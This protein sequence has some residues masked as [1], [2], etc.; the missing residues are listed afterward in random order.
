MGRC[1]QTHSLSA[2]H[3]PQE[4]W[5]QTRPKPTK[6]SGEHHLSD[7]WQRK[8]KTNNE[9]ESSPASDIFFNLTTD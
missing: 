3:T 5:W 7:P 1:R 6:Q 4:E 9:A 2:W 8:A